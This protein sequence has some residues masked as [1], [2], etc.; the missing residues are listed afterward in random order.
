MEICIVVLKRA[1]KIGDGSPISN[2]ELLVW[3]DMQGGSNIPAHIHEFLIES[4][5]VLTENIQCDAET[6]FQNDTLS[7]LKIQEGVSR[8]TDPKTKQQVT[9]QISSSAVGHESHPS[10]TTIDS[11][12]KRCKA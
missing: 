7:Q 12:R 6:N 9:S 10:R 4:D 2:K 11:V 8:I 3:S 1:K 5:N